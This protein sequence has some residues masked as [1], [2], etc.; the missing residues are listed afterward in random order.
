MY[1]TMTRSTFLDI[2]WANL[3]KVSAAFPQFQHYN[4]YYELIAVTEGPVYFQ[5]EN[6]KFVLHAGDTFLLKPW[7]QHKGWNSEHMTGEFYWVQFAASPGLE[8]FDF[9]QEPESE[10]PLQYGP[11]VHGP[12]ELRTGQDHQDMLIVPRHFRSSNRFQLLGMFEQLVQELT[13][14]KGY[15]RYR[16]SLLLGSMLELLSSDSLG[17]VRQDTSLP[18][19][20]VI[21]RSIISM[22]DNNYQRNLTTEE[23]EEALDRKYEYLCNVFKKYAGITIGTYIQQLR[24]QRAKYLLNSTDKS[25]QTIALEVGMEDPFHFSKL[26]KKKVGISPSEYRSR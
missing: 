1:Y 13:H 6:E 16:L 11:A 2:K 9:A 25:I 4:P 12:A 24:V 7:E 19:S 17:H 15:Y 14:S 22:A 21:Y 26:F 3:H 8:V 23:M 10:P 20:Y 5:S 18:A